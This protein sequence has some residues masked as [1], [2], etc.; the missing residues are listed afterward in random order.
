MPLPDVAF[1]RRLGVELEL[2]HI[3]FFAE[4]QSKRLDQPRMAGEQMKYFVERMR[5]KSGARRAGL[6]SPHF[7]AV[8]LEDGLGLVAQQCDLLFGKAVW[9]KQVAL[10]LELATLFYGELHDIRPLTFPGLR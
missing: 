4:Q 8:E 3:D 7:L 2:V 5:R 1:E 10:L 9:Q 6:L